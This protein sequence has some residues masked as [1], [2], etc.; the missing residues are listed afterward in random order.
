MKTPQPTTHCVHVP[1]RSL[2]YQA[3]CPSIKTN[4]QTILCCITFIAPTVHQCISYA[5]VTSTTTVC[6]LQQ[7][8]LNLQCPGFMKVLKIIVKMKSTLH[9]IRY[10]FQSCSRCRAVE[11]KTP[12]IHCRPAALIFHQFQNMYV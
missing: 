11:P 6:V 8:L 2:Y 3:T 9:D 10:S 5:V 12:L 4:A 1:S 7:P